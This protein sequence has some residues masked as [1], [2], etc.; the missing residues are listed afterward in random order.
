DTETYYLSAGIYVD[1]E[2]LLAHKKATV[3]VRPALSLNGTPV[4]LSALEDVSLVIASED[5]DGVTST[6][7]VT[8]FKL[9]G[10]A[11]S[12]FDFQVPA[13]LRKIG[14][15]L[16]AKVQNVSLN[17]KQDLSDSAE[18]LLNGIDA[19]EKIE[20]VHLAHLAGGYAVDVLGKTGEGKP[21]RTVHV[22][23]K[24]RLFTEPAQAGLQTDAAGR[25]D[26]GEL[27]EIEY[28]IAEMPPT[29]AHRWDLPRDAHDYPDAVHGQAGGSVQVPYIGT[30]GK[31]DHAELSLLE[32]RGEA[33]LA[34]RFD[35]LSIK[36][37]LVVISGLP[38]GDYDLLIR[39]ANVRVRIRLT[40]GPAREGYLF[41]PARMLETLNPAP[42]QIA[43]LT[44]G[45]DDVRIRLAN[46]TKAARVHVLATRFVPEYSP[47]A[48]LA[49]MSYPE[50]VFETRDT[51]PSVY[52]VGR[53]IGDEYRYVIERRQARKFPGV[54][55]ARPSLLLTPWDVRPTSTGSSEG[56]GSSSGLF[57]S[58]MSGESRGS[59]TVA[60][61]PNAGLFAG[62]KDEAD[63]AVAHFANLD[64]L[65]RQS[66]VLANLAADKDG[67]IV[68]PRKLLGGRQQIHVVAV[69]PHNTAYR[70]IA[71][72]ETPARP[73]DLRLK[74]ALDATKHFAQQKLIT[75]V[76][77]KGTFAIGDI[78]T[79]Q[80]DTYDTLGKAYALCSTLANNPEF[81]EFSFLVTWPK[82]TDAQKAEKYA[83]Y[84]SHELHFFLY[85]KDPAYFEKVVAPHLRN[86]KDKTF[87]DH[88]LLGADLKGYLAPW[89]YE[90]LNVV[91][92]I[93]LADRL[94]GERPAARRAVND[95]FDLI[96][97]DVE[98]FNHLFQAA[99]NGSS[100]ETADA[101]GMRRAVAEQSKKA[102]PPPPPQAPSAGVGT[103]SGSTEAARETPP[104][105]PVPLPQTVAPAVVVPART[106]RGGESEAAAEPE[107]AAKEEAKE[108]EP[109]AASAGLHAKS[110]VTSQEGVDSDTEEAER[111]A[112][113]SLY[114]ETGPAHEWAE[115]NYYRTPIEKQDASLIAVDAFWR[116][117]A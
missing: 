58:T 46:A 38:A 16:K 57:G 91:E 110:V 86:K 83:K 13:R 78:L 28:V 107:A 69:D 87:M 114:Q 30:A 93:L 70:E 112:Q 95:A 43:E 103:S 35:A 6:K 8:P 22:I 56:G 89:S 17:Q 65:P 74:A 32:L 111:P 5:H 108:E 21:G 39:P 50:A 11:E 82:L 42:L 64:F 15:T 4:K 62:G 61:D 73:R 75:V 47:F 101:M 29:V 51:T 80:L 31:P 33:F 36:D 63:G 115:N 55:A 60:G 19:G 48:Q 18:F 67:L 20:D 77:A 2:H 84:A 117:Y 52:V 3:I 90:R 66:V 81:N 59:G 27:R 24:H 34:D 97:P 76:P 14:F 7:V 106:E 94:A 10:S 12:T 41:S 72:D 9:S 45:K 102:T 37:G 98:R 53:N 100:L 40:N 25:I 105:A 99:L 68:I 96:P 71:L 109:S 1:R 88:Y 104:P 54:M 79:S 92:R 116:D 26:L 23:V 113:R 44:A 85:K 49:G